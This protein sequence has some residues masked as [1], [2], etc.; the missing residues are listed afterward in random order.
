[1]AHD[2]IDRYLVPQ[3]TADG[4][5]DMPQRVESAAFLVQVPGGGKELG[6]LLGQVACRILRGTVSPV[7]VRKIRS[8][9]SSLAG[10]G[11]LV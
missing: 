10:F 2:G 8:L 6:K 1:M 5:E 4:L 7:R 11:R 9:T 3:L